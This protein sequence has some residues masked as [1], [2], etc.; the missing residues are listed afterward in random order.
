MLLPYTHP[1]LLA[2]RRRELADLRRLLRM[3]AAILGLCAP[4]GAGKSS[5][6]LG[7]LVPTLRAEGM[8]VALVRHPREAGI[9]SRLV[10][11]LLEVDEALTDDDWRVLGVSMFPR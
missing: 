4:S 6:I 2:G 7:A 5:L 3:P 9:A 1:A 10:G 8:P 11:D